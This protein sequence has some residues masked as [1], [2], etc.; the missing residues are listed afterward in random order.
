MGL[1]F[2]AS[3]IPGSNIPPIF[4]FQDIVFH[5]FVYAVLGLCFARALKNTCLNIILSRVILWTLIFGIIYGIS[6]E[7][8]QA[9]VPYRTVSGFDVFMDG[10]GA[11]LGSLIQPL[12][13][14]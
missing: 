7:L 14:I 8:H 11:L 9:F 4:P 12:I 6:D 2:F 10:L 1:I 3:S 5:L 13:R